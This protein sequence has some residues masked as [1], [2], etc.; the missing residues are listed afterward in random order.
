M[1]SYK[2]GFFV[3]TLD[4]RAVATHTVAVCH[5][6]V[7]RGHEVTLI[8]SVRKASGEVPAGASIV[9]LELGRRRTAWGIVALARLL[10]RSQLDV[11]FC[12]GNGPGR[13]AVL[14]RK[15]ARTGPRVVAVEHTHYASAQ[16]GRIWKD[17]L[18]RTLYPGADVVAGVSR[19]VVEDLEER[20]PGLRGKTTVLPPAVMDVAAIRARCE[21]PPDHPWFQDPSLVVLVAVGNL[22]KRKA[23]DDLIE[24]FARLVPELPEARLVIVGRPDDPDF[25]A[26]VEE[27]MQWRGLREKIWFAG[28]Q[29]NPFAFMAH[30]DV[31][32]HAARSEGAG[33]V[34]IEAMACGI[35]VVAVDCLG[36]CKDMLQGG[37]AGVLV[38]P[39]DPEAMSQAVLRVLRDG[40]LR[41]DLVRR[42]NERARQFEPSNVASMHL[43]LVQRL[44]PTALP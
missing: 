16:R 8:C 32:V 21:D 15:L 23:Q 14:S 30:A 37:R 12:Q 1:P 31:F 13:A 39:K 5:Q 10:R 44:I 4:D 27:L 29:S 40:T 33:K 43:E 6:L 26:R 2:I 18:M 28:F 7:G 19:S 24:A 25:V 3:H 42:G 17:P 38:P 36:G 22:I 20:F 35:P 11:L 34:F 9:D 41:A